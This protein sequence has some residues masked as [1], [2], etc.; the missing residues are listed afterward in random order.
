VP[1]YLGDIWTVQDSTNR[2]T[3]GSCKTFNQ[4]LR[5]L[6]RPDSGVF[7]QHAQAD[8]V[9]SVAN[10]GAVGVAQIDV[11]AVACPELLSRHQWLL[12]LLQN[13]DFTF[14]MT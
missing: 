4:K 13:T 2:A 12:T 7:V 10:R 9:I 14:T 1:V 8:T 3:D 11:S 5:A 6:S